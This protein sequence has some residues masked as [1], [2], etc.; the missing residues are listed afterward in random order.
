M[1]KKALHRMMKIFWENTNVRYEKPER[2]YSHGWSQE[3]IDRDQATMKY[4]YTFEIHIGKDIILVDE[5]DIYKDYPPMELRKLLGARYAINSIKVIYEFWNEFKQL[6]Q[7]K[8]LAKIKKKKYRQR[9]E[10]FN[11]IIGDEIR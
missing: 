3:D 6:Y 10:L 5:K 8:Y 1:K 9:G 7:Y 2:W 4:G 11:E